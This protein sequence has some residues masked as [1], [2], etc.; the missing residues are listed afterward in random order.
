MILKTITMKGIKSRLTP[1]N[2]MMIV[3]KSV[4]KPIMAATVPIKEKRSFHKLTKISPIMQRK[5]ADYI[6]FTI[7]GSVNL[8]L[9]FIEATGFC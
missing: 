4:D 2:A 6:I 1:A 9:D 8:I 5:T 7:L 3:K